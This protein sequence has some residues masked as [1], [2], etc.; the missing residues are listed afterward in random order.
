[1]SAQQERMIDRWFPVAAV[2]EAC[3][4]PSGS[5]RVEKAVFSWFASRPIAQA[6]AAAITSLLPNDATAKADVE[7]AIRGGDADS[8]RSI[9][10]RVNAEFSGEAP[11]VLDMFSG[12]GIIPLEA[13][14]AGANAVG[15]DL[16]PVATLA[17]RLLGDFPARN[18]NSEKHM[19]SADGPVGTQTQLTAEP[20]A[21]LVADIEAFLREVERRVAE[22]LE[23]YYPRNKWE[24]F[25]WGYLW[26]TTVPC[27]GCNRRFPLLGSL[28]LRHPYDKGADKGQSLAFK[29]SKDGWSVDVVVG[30]PRQQP[31]YSS[32][33]KADGKRKKGKSATC[34]F[35][36]HVH[37]LEAIKSK[38][39]AGEYEDVLLVV[40]DFDRDG[41]TF[42]RVPTSKEITAGSNV[43]LD[44]DYG[45]PYPAVPAEEIPPGNVHTVMASGYGFK[46]F[47]ELMCARQTRMFIETCE[48]IREVSSDFR[49]RGA[50]EIYAGVLSC[51]A[52]STLCR[53]LRRSTRGARLLLHGSADGKTRSYVQTDHIFANESKINFQ[54]DFF[55]TG[56]G[57]GAGT[58]NSVASSTVRSLQKVTANRQ[59]GPCRFK[60]ASATALPFRDASVDVV[61]TDPPYYDMIE[62]ADA[63]DLFHVWLKR[64]LFDV[65]PD[66]FGPEAQLPDGL[67]DKN[68][69]IIVRRVHEPNRVRHD[70]AFYERMLS[71]SFAEARRVL[72]PLGHLVVIFGHSDPDAWRRLLGALQTAGFVVTSAWPS[73][74][75]TANTGVASIKVTVTIGCRVAPT[76]RPVGIGSEVDREVIE[77]VTER[78][79]QWDTDG[80]ALEDQ[81]MASY[82]PAMEVYGRY[83]R[84]LSPDGSTADLDH[85]LGL[86]R[87]AVRDAMRLRVDELPI[88]TFDAITRFAIFWLRAKGRNDVPKGEARFFAQAD[89][90][91]LDD[92]RGRVLTE[93]KAGFKIELQDE[94]P[95]TA[96]SSVFEVVRA[97]AHA[98]DTGGMEAVAA[99]LSEASLDPTNHH[100]WAV[101]GDFASHLSPS[102]KMAKALAGIKRSS[103]TISALAASGRSAANR[104]TLFDS[105]EA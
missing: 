9:V 74:T 57:D 91:R 11:L 66:L 75:E 38:G 60:V 23:P 1:M 73:R 87:R 18:W 88:E 30:L 10:E 25:P 97:M 99:V 101:V 105:V 31:T 103:A 100:I 63:S 44:V 54:F 49:K 51:Y 43:P 33:V 45:W 40:A 71:K 84:V 62:Y 50:S 68:D 72:K 32:G 61:I 13:S 3:G 79:A 98:W 76:G 55:E 104:P 67:Q 53:K 48:T 46:T 26:A 86:A 19:P 81:L 14:R 52:A 64:V 12:R 27:D 4:T 6:R 56:P 94:K 102:D 85:Y 36:Q 37:P 93:S 65:Q 21:N 89:E 95:V 8:L 35:C 28:A 29:V 92:L 39:E 77:A 15:I 96:T 90:L 24:Q 7:R 42:F 5:G 22:R 70:T 78:V 17:G 16:S 20:S 69:E 34:F 58:W 41:K 47:G 83:N 80:L 2:D 59:Y 82:G